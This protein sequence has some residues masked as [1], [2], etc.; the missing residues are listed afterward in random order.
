MTPSEMAMRILRYEPA[1]RLPVV[2]FGFWHETLQKWAQQG[3][4]SAEEARGWGDGNPVDA[5]IGA[6]LGFDFNWYSAFHP[7]S[8]LRPFFEGKVIEQFPDGARH[9][10]SGEGVIVLSQPGAGSIPAEIGHLLKDRASWEEH[11]RRRYQW[12][13]ER[14]TEGVVRVNDKMVRWD[15]GGLEF[16]RSGR[17]DYLYGLHCGSLF[18]VVR[19]I[20]GVEGSAYLS[21][22]DEPLFDEIIG[23]VAEVCYQNTKF[24]LATGAKFDFAHFWEDICYK[25]GPLV[26]PHVFE[27][28]VGPHYR[29][30]TDLVKSHGLDIISLDCDGMIDALIP[31]W[32]GN[33]VNTMFPI[34]VGTWDANIKPWREKY[35]KELRGVG[36]MNKV[37]F[38]R[39]RA[40]I[41]AE[42]ERLKPL[43]DLGGYIPCPDHRIAPDGEW[44]LVRYYCD[45]MRAVFG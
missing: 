32:F 18:G 21:V 39:D 3:H 23:A 30:I 34:E 35:G 43:V 16:L 10:L 24:A 37:V 15:Q 28:K 9:T 36:G 22:D 27:E 25:N 45:R 41:D 14:V 6:R 20:L 4:L 17:R 2:H 38:A 44:D 19:N 11:Y 8:H 42:V 40:A 13:P 5:A 7:A 29:R 1:E 12:S 26:S 33:G 31:T